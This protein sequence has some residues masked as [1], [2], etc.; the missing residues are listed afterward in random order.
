MGLAAGAPTTLAQS[1]AAGFWLAVVL[2][3]AG[4]GASAIVLTRLL[5]VVQHWCWPASPGV[6]LVDAAV[7]GT[8]LGREGAPKRSGAVIANAL[9]D[10]GRLSDE[11][12]RLLVACGRAPEWRTRRAGAGMAGAYGVPLGG[13]L[14]A[15][16]VMRGALALRM[17]LPALVCSL[18][19]T[20]ISWLGL[21]DSVTRDCVRVHATPFVD[22]SAK[23][24][25]GR[26]GAI[27]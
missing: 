23:L 17:V 5:D 7:M 9:S 22:T 25:A 8:S 16:E 19:A 15:L 4:A 27:P 12:R 2:T 26:E 11:Q 14:F 18:I 3:R 20:A 24:F 13:V 1:G 10:R 21:P 6:S